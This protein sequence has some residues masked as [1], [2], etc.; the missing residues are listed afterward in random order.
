MTMLGLLLSSAANASTVVDQ[1][2]PAPTD[3]LGVSIEIPCGTLTVRGGPVV[4]VKVSGSVDDPEALSVSTSPGHVSIEV[5]ARWPQKSC[6]DLVVTVPTVAAVDAETV[7][8][9][10][11][12]EGVDGPLDLET[13]SGSISVTGGGCGV[14]AESISGSVAV[15]GA[16][17]RAE[18]STVSGS[19]VLDRVVGP[20]RV[21]SVSGTIRVAGGAPLPALSAE[22]VSASITVA[23]QFDDDARV[24]LES[25]SGAVVFALPQQSNTR[26]EASSL[27]GAIS[28]AFGPTARASGG[29]EYAVVL[30]EGR[31]SVHLETFS[32]AIAVSRLELP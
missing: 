17:K 7:S 25:H 22:T 3:E 13:T 15:R 21:E 12:V 23:A 30:G 14:S 32:G 29:S 26:I 8:A 31:G 27:S 5:E 4:K 11:V 9:G 6:A 2:R 24:S 19:I 28:S 18:V 20:V 10:I 1:E 16:I